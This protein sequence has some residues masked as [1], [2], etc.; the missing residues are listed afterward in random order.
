MFAVLDDGAHVVGRPELKASDGKGL[1]D[2]VRIDGIVRSPERRGEVFRRGELDR[3][4]RRRR[5]LAARIDRGRDR[6]VRVGDG[7]HHDTRLGVVGFSIGLSIVSR[8]ETGVIHAVE[9]RLHPVRRRRRNCA[10]E[11]ALVNVADKVGRPSPRI[12]PD[13]ERIV[14]VRRR[15]AGR[16][17]RLLDSAFENRGGIVCIDHEDVLPPGPGE[18]RR[19]RVRGDVVA[20]RTACGNVAALPDHLPAAVCR[21]VAHLAREESDITGGLTG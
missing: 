4:V 8:E 7:R 21:L 17:G 1:G 20:G 12:A 9:F 13:R 16:C 3:H 6:R 18:G 15:G 2:V 19:R 10:E 11:T 5:A 14:V